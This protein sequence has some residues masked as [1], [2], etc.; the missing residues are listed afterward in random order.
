MTERQARMLAKMT[1]F[2]VHRN[3]NFRPHPIVHLDQLG[4]SRMSRDV[5]V[6]LALRNHADAKVGQLVHDPADRDLVPRDDPRR[7]YDGIALAELQ[8]VRS[9][10]DS[11]ERGSRLALPASGDDKHLALRQSHR[12][13]EADR[14]RE[15]LQIAG[16]LGDTEDP[17][18]RTAGDADLAIG[19][20]CDAADGLKP[21]GV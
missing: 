7:E 4:T 16:S 10:G 3:D 19:F 12:L 17:L 5:D 2:A 9:G 15:V 1:R 20:V 18:E 8:V 13:V 11:A 6:S 14:R 21:R